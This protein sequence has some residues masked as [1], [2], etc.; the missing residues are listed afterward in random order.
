LFQNNKIKK[1]KLNNTLVTDAQIKVFFLKI[2]LYK[3]KE[4][5]TRIL[6]KLISIRMKHTLIS[7]D[8]EKKKKEYKHGLSLQNT[9]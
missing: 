1:V 8:R 9:L 3:N 4:L 7:T 5:K 2:T 6:I